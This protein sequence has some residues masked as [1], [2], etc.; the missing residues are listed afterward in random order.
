MRLARKWVMENAEGKKICNTFAYTC[1]FGVAGI[2]R[3]SLVLT[4]LAKMGKCLS[5]DNIDSSKT[6]LQ[7]GKE[8]YSLNG[9]KFQNREFE[10][11]T[12]KEFCR[13]F[14]KRCRKQERQNENKQNAG[15]GAPKKQ[16]QQRRFDMVII[17]PSPPSK[18]DDTKEPVQRL[19]YYGVNF[20]YA[21]PTV[22]DGGLVLLSCHCK[23]RSWKSKMFF[24]LLTS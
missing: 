19:D 9:L 17:D 23:V 6:A 10:N 15:D 1:G 3:N 4:S 24:R 7:S 13:Q 11:F 18:G 12:T 2:S 16:K 21:A 20:K 8:N 14:M 22:A 5:V